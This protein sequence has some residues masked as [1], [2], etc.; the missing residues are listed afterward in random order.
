MIST[1]KNQMLTIMLT[2]CLFVVSAVYAEQSEQPKRQLQ[3]EVS[4]MSID[5]DWP[6]DEVKFVGYFHVKVDRSLRTWR[7]SL[8]EASQWKEMSEE[9]RQFIRKLSD[10]YQY[11][12]YLRNH[13]ITSPSSMNTRHVRTPDDTYTYQIPGVSEQDVRK[14]AEAVIEAFD[15]HAR[16]GIEINQENLK[17]NRAIIT[18][19]EIIL[20]KLESE[21]NKL[22]VQKDE[23]I[24][25]YSK[26]NYGIDSEKT[27][28][29]HARKSTEE[30]AYHLRLVDFEL[31]GLRAK[32]DS[33][34]RFKADE[35]IKD[36]DTLTRLDQMLI[37]TEVERSGL[38]ARRNAYIS[39]FKQAKELHTIIESGDEAAA[40]KAIWE[41]K[42]ADAQ[43]AIPDLEGWLENPPSSTRPVEV[44]E[45]N[46]TIYPVHPK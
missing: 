16:E 34:S 10:D 42:L 25:E 37:T 23:K 46:V 21:C 5:M 44:Y 2:A 39:A 45:N 35:K 3:F 32:I 22:K 33:I 38:L 30:L 13:N 36:Q 11:K 31:I 18:E 14:M 29:E 1:R 4:A 6:F 27:I 20:P 7:Y 17:K 41:K 8:M 9:Q 40:Q 12:R 28:S 19:A 24:A 43:K 26:A 15:R